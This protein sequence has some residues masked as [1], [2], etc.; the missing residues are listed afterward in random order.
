MKVFMDRSEDE[1]VLDEERPCCVIRIVDVQF[2]PAMGQSEMRH[3]VT[4][5]F[6][7][8]EPILSSATITRRLAGMIAEANAL[9]AADRTVSGML[10]SFELRSATAEIDAMPDLGCATLTGELT[11]LTPRNDFTTILG[12]SGLH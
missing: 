6:D 10:E 1:P 9:I 8:Y 7:F 12:A 11:F 3:D 2:S 4:V 5:D